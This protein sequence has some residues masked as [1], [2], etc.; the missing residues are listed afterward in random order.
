MVCLRLLRRDRQGDGEL[1]TEDAE[2]FLPGYSF[3]LLLLREAAR[4]AGAEAPLDLAD[5]G[6]VAVAVGLKYV[7]KSRPHAN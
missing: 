4:G 6:V 2:D 5:M 7:G 3:S 1:G